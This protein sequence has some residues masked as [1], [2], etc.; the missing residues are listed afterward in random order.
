MSATLEADAMTPQEITKLE[1]SLEE[2]VTTL[3]HKR[4]RKAALEQQVCY[5]STHMSCIYFS[6]R[7]LRDALLASAL[8]PQSPRTLL[9]LSHAFISFPHFLF[10]IRLPGQV[11]DKGDEFV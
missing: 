5:T 3:S 11:T 1:K 2:D 10:V 7:H 9:S 6:A 8:S 4:E